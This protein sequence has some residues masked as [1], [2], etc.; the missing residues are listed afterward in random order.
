MLI[1]T[2]GKKI[3]QME[4][5][6]MKKQNIQFL[7]SGKKNENL[8]V[9]FQ[10]AGINWYNRELYLKRNISEIDRDNY[11]RHLFVA[12]NRYNYYKFFIDKGYDVLSIADNYCD[13]FGWY[14][15]NQKE[16]IS[17]DIAIFINGF[18]ER[19][20]EGKVKFFGSSKGAYGALALSQYFI[21]RAE[22]LAIYPVINP[23]SFYNEYENRE[24]FLVQKNLLNE[25]YEGSLKIEDFFDQCINLD[26][27]KLKIVLGKNENQ[28]LLFFKKIVE[29]TKG[30]IFIDMRN[31]DHSGYLSKALDQVEYLLKDE[32]DFDKL[33]ITN[34]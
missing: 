28:T 24:D 18:L 20:K 25:N 7:Y 15:L 2:I 31:E 17:N 12:H 22:I 5:N 6:N 30:K 33:T 19:Y 23:I 26:R 34:L 29:S 32:D 13:S 9:L 21:D 4:L 10:A 11:N 1:V 14:V 8:I 27:I 16:Y 3:I